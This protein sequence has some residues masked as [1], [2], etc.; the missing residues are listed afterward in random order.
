MAYEVLT[1]VRDRM[2]NVDKVSL[3]VYVLFPKH[4]GISN[5]FYYFQRF[6]QNTYINFV[7]IKSYE[8]HCIWKVQWSIN[9][10][11]EEW[12]VIILYYPSLIINM[13]MTEM[14]RQEE[15]LKLSSTM[16]WTIVTKVHL[17]NKANV[18]ILLRNEAN[19][20]WNDS[21]YNNQVPL[22]N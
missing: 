22:I 20:L 12:A 21:Q 11:K 17:I 10:N 8:Q 16:E 15:P 2:W 1:T 14:N 13:L 19:N 7:W 9:K 5:I 4:M 3:C 18:L 6:E